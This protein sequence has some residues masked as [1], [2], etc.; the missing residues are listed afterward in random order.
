MSQ[1]Y[2]RLALVLP[3]RSPPPILQL[4]KGMP[5]VE[6]GKALRARLRQRHQALLSL[7]LMPPYLAPLSA[8]VSDHFPS[9]QHIA[10]DCTLPAHSLLRVALPGHR[11]LAL[12]EPF[13]NHPA[14]SPSHPTLRSLLPLV[15]APRLLSPFH[16]L[17]L[18]QLVPA[19]ALCF[20][21]LTPIQPQHQPLLLPRSAPHLLPLTPEDR[22]VPKSPRP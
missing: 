8:A 3:L 15:V 11:A 10:M 20:H 22:Q 13:L 2:L 14:A 19:T 17:S 9:V 6:V 21:Q 18:Q 5:M 16:Q 4:V 1:Q 12:G 7:P